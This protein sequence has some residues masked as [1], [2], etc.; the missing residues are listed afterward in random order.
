MKNN[1][2]K[3]CYYKKQE[4]AAGKWYRGFEKKLFDSLIN[5]DYGSL[6]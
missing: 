6:E 4:Q 2:T 3:V 1:D 5:V